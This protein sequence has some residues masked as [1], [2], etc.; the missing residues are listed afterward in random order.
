MAR[1]IIP[2]SKEDFSENFLRR[3][4]DAKK[5]REMLES[6]WATNLLTIS[7][8]GLSSDGD[9]SVSFESRVE[10]MPDNPTQGDSK[11]NMNYAFKYLQ[12]LHSQMSSNPPSAV[13]GPTSS[14]YSDVNAADAADRIVR[15]AIKQYNM[16]EV[17][18]QMTLKTLVFGIGWVKIHWD[19]DSGDILD[20]DES[21]NEVIT[22]GDIRIYSPDTTDVWVD[23]EARRLEDIRWIIERKTISL[24]EAKFLFPDNHE[25][26]DAFKRD[27]EDRSESLFYLRPKN[28]SLQIPMIDLYEMH[29]KGL[30]INGGVGRFATFLS[31]GT[32]LGE[33]GKNPHFNHELPYHGLTY[34]DHIGVVYGKSTVEYV[35][36]LQEMLSNIDSAM[37]DS[38]QAH[39]MV[40]MV[41]YGDIED[42]AISDSS[43]DWI[44]L[45]DPNGRV[46]FVN[47]PSLPGDMWNYRAQLYT[48]IQELFG[49]NDSMMG[50]QRREQSA[51]SQQTAIEAGTMVNRRLFVKYSNII[52]KTYRQF[53]GIVTDKWTTPK[54]IKVI[55]KEQEFRAAEVVGADISKGWDIKVEYGAAL[56][57]DPNMRREAIMLMWDQLKDAGFS[58][59]QLLAKMKLDDLQGVFDRNERAGNRQYEQFKAM[60]ESYNRGSPMLIEPQDLEDHAGRLEWAYG[61]L[62]SREFHNLAPDLKEIIKEHIRKR[63]AMVEEQ[64]VPEQAPAAA[65]P[66]IPPMM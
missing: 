38:I 63:E 12:F 53:L 10:L 1:K 17:V 39:G 48:A 23:P 66:G 57:L 32:L 40:R 11:I 36:R 52:E 22:E 41:V 55:G 44:K 8:N 51:V 34:L 30:H 62:E 13:I 2:W 20:F 50:I 18:D 58:S 65:P 49:I 6:Q 26:I 42:E 9:I 25:E 21:T 29:E 27:Q 16:Q 45:S 7:P 3:F 35:A 64:A 56:P 59:K 54:V 43:W 14:D 24:E 28:Y 37:L 19:E 46:N 60:I 15:W 31:N 5:H 33:P 47:P 61:Y 4:E